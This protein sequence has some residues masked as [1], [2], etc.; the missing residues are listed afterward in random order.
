[1]IAL[2]LGVVLAVIFHENIAGPVRRL[3]GV[4]EEIR[5]G[6][7]KAQASIESADEIGIL[8]ATFNNMTSQLRQTLFQVRKEKK[9]ADDLLNV[10]IPIGV[11]LSSEKD[12]NRLLETMLVEAKSFCHANAGSLY[13]RPTGEDHLRFVIMRNDLQNIALGG[14]TG[15]EVPFQ[16]LPLQDENG[17]PNHSYVAT[18]VALSGDTVN[19]ANT[20][21]VEEG[22]DFSGLKSEDGTISFPSPTSMLTIPLKNSQNEVL[23]VL[24]LLDA[25][26]PENEHIIPFDQNLQQ[27]MESF[28]SLASAALAAYIR[29]QGLRREIQQLRIEIDE[30]KRQEQVSEIV[31]SDFFT[32]LQA[33][34]Q[35]IRRRGRRSKKGKKGSAEESDS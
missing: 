31:D 5:E 11:E 34:A 22:F 8:A 33:R 6:D 35:E 29:E 16:P 4:A 23:G 12:F 26:E 10:V 20:A 21:E 7:L 18:H 27:M 2:I 28:S 9:R 17:Q 19:I 1:V 25:Q 24:Q 13:L 30:A 14:T 32:D 3:T 15:K